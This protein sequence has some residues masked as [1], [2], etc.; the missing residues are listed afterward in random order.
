MA[1]ATAC[2]VRVPDLRRNGVRTIGAIWI[3]MTTSEYWI[4]GPYSF[5]LDATDLLMSIPFYIF[6]NQIN[7][8][9]LFSHAFNGGMDISAAMAMSGQFVSFERFLLDIL[10]VWVANFTHKN[11]AVGIGF[12]GTYLVVRKAFEGDRMISLSLAALYPVTQHLIIF[13]SWVHGLGYPLI[14][15]AAYLCVF[16][17]GKRYYLAGAIFVSA[18]YSI[19]SSQPLTGMAFFPTMVFSAMLCDTHRFRRMFVATILP[20]VFVFANWHES[21][22]AKALI[23]PLTLRGAE[24][25]WATSNFSKF[26]SVLAY[27]LTQDWEV[28]LVAG[29]GLLL[30]ATKS[31]KNTGI[32]MLVFFVALWSGALL[33]QIPWQEIGLTGMAGVNFRY[34]VYSTSFIALLVLAIAMLAIIELK[35]VGLVRRITVATVLALAISKFVWYKAV[36]LPAWLTQGGLLTLT[37]NLSRLKDQS[38]APKEPFRVVTIPYRMSP[39]LA[40]AAG[41]DALDATSN[42]V[43]DSTATYW[44][45]AVTGAPKTTV[46]AGFMIIQPDGINYKCCLAYNVT[47]ILNLEFLRIANVGYILSTL[48]LQGSNLK[49]VAGPLT[50]RFP[51]RNTLAVKE[52][53][54]AYLEAI[55]NPAPV[56][57]YGIGNAVPRVFVAQKIVLVENNISDEFFLRLIKQ[58]ASARR[59]VVKN[60]GNITLPITSNNLKIADYQLIPDGFD[61]K[62]KGDGAG[63]IVI[64]APYIPFWKAYADGKLVDVSSANLVHMIVSIPAG[65]GLL[66]LRYERPLFRDMLK[67]KI[68]GK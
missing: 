30:L 60:T 31:L 40:S 61:I 1:F 4:A 58:H 66:K 37:E 21:L 26:I 22:Y 51:P 41:L 24:F 55:K 14:P 16:R 65:T 13:H 49:K 34:I 27:D 50:D 57:I 45:K 52:R 2:C 20:A 11:M 42:L 68:F 8:G 47:K 10:P 19:S 25:S 67:N 64:N 18:F 12:W 7:D 35:F 48:P 5:V 59:A 46:D 32:P 63:S 17:Y 53:T 33:N 62:L 39:N 15:L 38:W 3:L 36:T 54:M 43:L 6:Q 29:I 44:I 9:R 23:A 28:S 56:Y